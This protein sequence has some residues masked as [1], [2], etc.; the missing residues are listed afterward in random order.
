MDGVIQDLIRETTTTTGAGLTLTLDA[1]PEYGRFAD[2]TGGVGTV[3]YYALRSGSDTEVGLGTVQAT[4]TFDRTTPIATVVSGVYDNTSPARITLSGTSVL[5]I[6]PTAAA[7]ND[8]LSD[9]V[10]GSTIQAYDVDTAKLD[11]VQSF[12]AEQTFKE[13]KATQY[14][15]TGTVIDPANGSIQYKTL[16]GNTTFTE[17]LDDGQAVTLRIDD[18]SA[19]TITWPAITW[20][21]A[22]APT[23]PT[24][25]YAEINLEQ[26]N[27]VV[28]GVHVG[29][30]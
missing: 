25:G 17:S 16:T 19:Y 7:L 9:Y 3:V 18:G 24:T 5:A 23:L 15:L 30:F 8:I 29:D 26:M 10:I 21:D 11:V 6:T 20:K 22:T 12:T 1:D 13:L 2:V 4:N 14:N 27:G 28:Y